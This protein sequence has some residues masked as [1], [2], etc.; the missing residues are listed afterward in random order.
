MMPLTILRLGRVSYPDGLRLQEEA[1]ARVLAGGRDECLLLEHDPVVTLGKRG[2]VVDLEALARLATPVIKTDRGGF[3]TWHG[4]GQ[5]IAY[6]ILDTGRARI[7][8]RRLIRG[9]GALM[10]AVA[11]DLGVPDLV[12]DDERPGVYRD[13]RKLGSLGLHLSRGVTMHGLALNV[14]NALDGFRAIAPCGFAD[15]EVST[16][17]LEAG[18]PISMEAAFASIERH[19]PTLFDH[20]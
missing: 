19:L 5:L 10:Q 15:L 7:G 11:A 4:P 20:C 16:L 8:V 18:H 1:R 14:C 2:G 12:Y 13:G 9:L 17:S 6:P 3:A